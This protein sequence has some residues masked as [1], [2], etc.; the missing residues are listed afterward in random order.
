MESKN[1]NKH[2]VLEKLVPLI[3]NTAMRY[4]VIPLEID[5]TKES[6]KWFLRIFLYKQEGVTLDDCENVSR[7]LN[8]FLDELIP[9]KFYLEV[10]SPGLDRKLKS[11]KEYIIFQGKTVNIKLK[12]LVEG[13]NEKQFLAKIVD[14]HPENGLI[15]EKL[16]DNKEYTLPKD[17]L[18]KV[19]LH[20]EDI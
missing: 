15:V 7:S 17:K 19:Q 18:H 16:D 12:S 11:E 9:I 1:F 2:E 3:E 4:G 5:F 8:P 10:S 6:G 13:L 20:I 14:F